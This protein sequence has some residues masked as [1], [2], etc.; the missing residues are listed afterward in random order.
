MISVYAPGKAEV[1]E[2][3]TQVAQ[4]IESTPSEAAQTLKGIMDESN[5][6]FYVITVANPAAADILITSLHG[7]K[8]GEDPEFDLLLSQELSKNKKASNFKYSILQMFLDDIL[9]EEAVEYLAAIMPELK[10]ELDSEKTENDKYLTDVFQNLFK[11]NLWQIDVANRRMMSKVLN[12]AAKSGNRA[13]A[14][15]L[16]KPELKE[17]LFAAIKTLDDLRWETIQY[18]GQFG[19]E[20]K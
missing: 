13:L 5:K 20:L 18:L 4:A 9:A 17:E 6:T 8:A 1:L 2:N 7:R 11:N 16:S 14:E 15:F 19:I 3:N 12:K 10:L